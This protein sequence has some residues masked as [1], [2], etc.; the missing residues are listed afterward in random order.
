VDGEANVEEEDVGGDVLE[1]V[2]LNGAVVDRV[3]DVD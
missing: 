2:V 3:D 1:Y